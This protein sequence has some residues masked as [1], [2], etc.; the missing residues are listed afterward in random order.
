MRIDKRHLR[1]LVLNTLVVIGIVTVNFLFLSKMENVFPI[2]N[3]LAG[4]MIFLPI[5]FWKYTEYR[6]VK[7][8]EEVFPNFLRDLIESM[9]GGMT[10]EQAMKTLKKN[11]YRNLNPHVKRMAAQLDWSITIETVLS[12]F[13]KSTKSSLIKRTISSLI[14]SHRFGGNLTDT[15]EALNNASLEVERLKAERSIYLYSQVMTGYITFFVFIGVI[16]AMNSF[17]IPSLMNINI[18]GVQ[19]GATSQT[20]LVQDYRQLFM[21]LILLQGIFAGLSVGKMSEG[22]FINGLKHSVI[23]VVIGLLIFM[24]AGSLTLG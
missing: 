2:V 6:N 13:A 3:I 12:R 8:I 9:R 19:T 21:N 1:L 17:L 20:N 18:V 4:V 24:V 5:I 7:I 22:A 23:M 15:L 14:E 11:D 16:I 10:V